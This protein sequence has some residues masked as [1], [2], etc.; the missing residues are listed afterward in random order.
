MSLETRL[1]ALTAAVGAD[2]KAL[3]AS[4]AEQ[5]QKLTATYVNATVT[6]TN[7]FAG[8]TPLANK[9]Y[10]IEAVL[11]AQSAA[12]ASGIQI[13]LLGP[14]TGIT[15]ATARVVTPSGAAADLIANLNALN[16]YTAATASL[17][18][19]HLILLDGVVEV[20]TPG[21]GNIRIGARA[22]S[23]AA[24]AVQIFPGSFMRWKDLDTVGVPFGSQIKKT[25][26]TLNRD[27]IQQ[28]PVTPVMIVP[29]TEPNLNY[30]VAATEYPVLVNT[31]FALKI[32]S[33]YANFRSEGA[34]VD[35][36]PLVLTYGQDWSLTAAYSVNEIPDFSTGVTRINTVDMQDLMSAGGK[37]W[38]GEF[39]NSLSPSEPSLKDNG[40]WLTMSGPPG[41]L[42]GGSVGDF[43]KITVWYEMVK[44]TL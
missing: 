28:L 43:L 9:R 19:P 38:W 24:N 44:V 16:A 22:E 6:G 37:E 35:P 40:L 30:S 3:Q 41:A 23:A 21:A 20:G 2:I 17:T 33:S 31:A 26:V 12:A 4:G 11:V 13:A 5:Q 18:T 14:S 36:N 39:S 25:E 27:A 32:G 34:N 29:P 42:T 7:V 15:R 1:T 10:A 8:F